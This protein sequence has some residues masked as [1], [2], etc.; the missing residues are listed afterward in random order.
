M[1]RLTAHNTSN[2]SKSLYQWTINKDFQARPWCRMTKQAGMK[3]G[4]APSHWKTNRRE[5][6][7]EWSWDLH[8][9]PWEPIHL[10]TLQHLN[11][12]KRIRFGPAPNVEP[13][14]KHYR[15]QVGKSLVAPCPW[16]RELGACS[17]RDLSGKRACST[18]TRK[19]KNTN[20][21]E[22]QAGVK[23]S[24][25]IGFT[26]RRKSGG[27]V[28]THAAKASKTRRKKTSG[29]GTRKLSGKGKILLRWDRDQN[30]GSGKRR[31]KNNLDEKIHR[32]NRRRRTD[33]ARDEWNWL[34]TK[35]KTGAEPARAREQNL[36]EPRS[37][38][39][40]ESTKTRKSWLRRGSLTEPATQTKANQK[41]DFFK[42][43]IN[44]YTYIYI[45][46]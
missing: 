36:T 28:C 18:A 42:H 33:Q 27:A 31:Q 17:L 19:T 26:P 5:N 6:W 15:R 37:K 23:S 35:I 10:A 20:P 32:E 39:I 25:G 2:R 34:A 8:L 43:S 13:K 30:A 38:A 46:I 40:P 9:E 3:A 45:Y 4:S 16:A 14:L 22:D 11:M 24:S 12:I 21:R 1:G 44:T 7:E 41:L 29:A